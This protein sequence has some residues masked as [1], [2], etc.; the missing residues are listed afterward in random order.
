MSPSTDKLASEHGKVPSVNP[1]R[2][3][4]VNL[5]F[6]RERLMKLKYR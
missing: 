4:F 2:D 3:D 1:G 6:I 5:L